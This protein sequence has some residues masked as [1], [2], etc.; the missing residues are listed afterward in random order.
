ML[1]PLSITNSHNR[2]SLNVFYSVQLFILL[3]RL[4]KHTALHTVTGGEKTPLKTSWKQMTCFIHV[5]WWRI[6]SRLIKSART[7]APTQPQRAQKRWLQSGCYKEN[8]LPQGPCWHDT[9]LVTEPPADL[10]GSCCLFSVLISCLI[11]FHLSHS[12]Y[13]MRSLT[14]F[15]TLSHFI[16]ISVFSPQTLFTF[17]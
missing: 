5:K 4:I 16:Y 2:D 14:I 3:H 9:L 12:F 13:F 10:F 1:T 6:Q 15:F 8:G 7:S 11:S 17:W